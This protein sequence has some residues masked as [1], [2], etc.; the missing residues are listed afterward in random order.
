VDATYYGALPD[1]TNESGLAAVQNLNGNEAAF[2]NSQGVQYVNYWK[3]IGNANWSWSAGAEAPASA[4]ID[5]KQRHSEQVNCQF[6]DGHVKALPYNR[7]IGD[8][9]Y[10]TT[11]KDGAHPNCN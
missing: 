1:V 9:C 8:I 5:G 2:L 7:A 10:W 3:N 6:V 4:I 11:D